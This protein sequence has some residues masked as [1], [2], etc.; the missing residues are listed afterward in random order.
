MSRLVVCPKAGMG[1]LALGMS[2]VLA[3][4]GFAD[5]LW[6]QWR[7]PAGTGI[8]P[9]SNFPT[10]WSNEK[11]VLFRF[12]LPGPA[13]ST[14]VVAGDRIF[15]TT[16]AGDDLHL[17][18][19][20]TSGTEIWNRKVTTGNQT[21][22]VDEGNSAS[23]SPITDGTHVWAMF[24]DGSLICF[25]ID[26]E[27]VWRRDLQKDY[28]AFDIQFG[29]TSTPVM[30]EGTIYLQLI[31]GPWNREPSLGI[32]AALDAKSGEQ[33]WQVERRTD[34]I[35]ENKHSYA[36]PVIYD[37]GTHKYLISHGADYVTGHDL[38]TGAEVW[39]CGGLNPTGNYNEYLRFVAS[40]AVGPGLIVA[41]TAK[42]GP[43]IAIRPGGTGDITESE[44][45]AW[46][47][48]ETTPDVP[49]PIVTK[50][51]IY[52]CREN[53]VAVCLDAKT[54]ATI[55][56]E[57]TN[58]HNHRA[59][60]VLSGERWLITSRRGVITVLQ[61]GPDFKVLA[62]NDMKEPV[63]SSPVIIGDR[64]YIR[65]FDALYAIGNK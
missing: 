1:L 52:L 7:G 63:A 8:V 62:T 29:M 58:G 14:P 51:Y 48:E 21:A 6:P 50:D 20:S 44:F 9:N 28:G 2:W 32:L 41:P 45:V 22:R 55:Y 5:D 16:A 36:S 49:S 61:A 3:S 17:L 25:T 12:P 46:K 65:S 4:S 37:D 56:E 15:L 59:S 18:C 27:E 26:G 30:H 38:T 34:A 43:V 57:R 11:N 13:G 47:A 42:G 19:I 31:H 54:G 53:G 33:K 23:P 24:G 40:P 35:S 10:E 64:L 39:R 60:P